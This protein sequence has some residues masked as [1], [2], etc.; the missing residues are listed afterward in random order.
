MVL[1]RRCRRAACSSAGSKGAEAQSDV[2]VR[3]NASCLPHH[4]RRG[5]IDLL[6]LQTLMALIE[7]RRYDELSA[8]PTHAENAQ[9]GCDSFCNTMRLCWC[10]QEMPC[11]PARSA[12]RV[13]AADRA[14]IEGDV[15]DRMVR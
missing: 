4:G 5:T 11:I 2:V 15:Y 7:V 6:C 3:N 9:R 13:G 1:Q 14:S 12:S 10:E 8:K